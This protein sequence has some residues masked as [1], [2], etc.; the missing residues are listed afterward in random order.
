MIK[1]EE[2]GGPLGSP[3]GSLG[4]GTLSSLGDPSA[5]SG[6]LVGQLH[7]QQ[8]LQHLYQQHPG[9]IHHG[10]HGPAAG[11]A[12]LDS[13]PPPQLHHHAAGPN[14]HHQLSPHLQHTAHLQH[15]PQLLPEDATA[16]GSLVADKDNKSSLNEQASAAGAG[17]GAAAKKSSSGLRRQEKPP[18]SYIALI[19]MA[20]QHS[21][22]KRL[23]LSEIYTFLQQKFSFFRGSYQ[24]W[25]NSVRH[26]L[27]LNECFI[28]LPKGLGRPGKGHYWTIDP[29][30]ELMFEEGS[31]RRRPRGFR[32]KCQ[33]IQAV[34]AVQALRPEL[35]THQAVQALH[36]Y[37]HPP[38]HSASA[39]FNGGNVLAAAAAHAMDVPPQPHQYDMHQHV[40]Q[41]VHQ[42]VHQQACGPSCGAPAQDYGYGSYDYGMAYSQ[43]LVDS[44]AAVAA[45]AAQ[46]PP[47][48]AMPM[49]GGYM[50]APPSPID[51][52]PAG[53]SPAPPAHHGHGGGAPSPAH[54]DLGRSA[55]P[56]AYPAY[57]Y[58]LQTCITL[59]DQHGSRLGL[60]QPCDRKPFGPGPPP[61]LG[62][63]A[64]SGGGSPTQGMAGAGLG[65]PLA[66][67]STV[68]S[69]LPSPPAANTA[70][71][72]YDSVKYT[73][74]S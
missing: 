12:G 56:P 68:P 43:S 48:G 3:L 17:A 37:H 69:T 11:P 47:Y 65:G 33:A 41:H 18:Y 54:M 14:L 25:K 59:Q 55:T 23:T 8:H 63:G 45:P 36:Q 9:V 67:A 70:H 30:S 73:T 2:P 51:P 24:G 19:V 20:I 10:H 35:R 74:A 28:K 34:Q 21:P 7:L 16:P 4:P 6:Q 46:W 53:P 15:R 61:M 64:S 66:M 57:Q 62:S 40:Q 58:G 52:S 26:N 29:A 44:T 42:H 72:F 13:P 71:V 39:F 32:R 31:Y 50:K 27:S 49:D 38:P 5:G 60:Q 22:V 1:C